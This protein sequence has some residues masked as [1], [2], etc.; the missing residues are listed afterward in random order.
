[1]LFIHKTNS[2]T[3]PLSS[4]EK[5][6]L[7]NPLDGSFEQIDI[8]VK[9]L[10]TY[11]EQFWIT[12]SCNARA[13]LVICSLHGKIYI[14]CKKIE[15][16]Q[17]NCFF[18][19][20]EVTVG[21]VKFKP[22]S[23][24]KTK[25]YNL[26]KAAIG[27]SGNNSTTYSEETKLRSLSRLGQVL[28]TILS[29]SKVNNLSLAQMPSTLEQLKLITSS[30]QDPKKLITKTISLNKCYK[31]LLNNN[32]LQQAELFLQSAKNWF[33]TKLKPFVLFSSVV[34]DISSHS[35]TLKKDN[36]V[37]SV[38]NQ[39]ATTSNWIDRTKSAPYFLITA[40]ILNENNNI[41]L[42]D[43]FA[44][45]IFSAS[46]LMPIESNYER[47]ILKILFKFC[48]L[49][50]EVIIEKPLFDI[51]TENKE[52]FRP[53]FI[54]HFKNKKKIYIEVLGSNNR[55]YLEHKLNI[56]RIAQKYCDEHISVKAYDIQNA[57]SSFVQKLESA[58]D[59][60]T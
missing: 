8:F 36:H 22:A 24:E 23:Y 57:Y 55:H 19:R 32:T 16:H 13:L 38:K 40:A 58:L 39:V 46:C 34:T 48:K 4:I 52:R 53:D 11:K 44:M 41:I 20:H 54:I 25:Q 17:N 50:P 51:F 29:D 31:Y 35:F 21:K 26:Y 30:F 27:L 59:K 49:L 37:F 9:K 7:A 45:P 42:N 3:H 33:P 28:Y 47:T 2:Y 6:I 56:E 60:Y 1:M 12:C 10:H 15:D 5:G 18:V 14:R 43:A